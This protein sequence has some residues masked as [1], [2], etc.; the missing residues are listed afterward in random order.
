M[1]DKSTYFYDEF[2]D[3]T[4]FKHLNY[5]NSFHK[6]NYSF[7]K[8]L[9]YDFDNLIIIPVTIN[10]CLKIKDFDFD[11][12]KYSKHIIDTLNEGFS[13][14]SYSKYKSEKYNLK[15][16][17][18]LITDKTQASIIF[19]Y[20]NC[21]ND[22]KIRFFLNSID[23]HDK[24]F[25]YD[26]SSN[27]DFNLFINN[28]YSK[29][30]IIKNIS[31]LNINIIN[32]KCNSIGISTFP[33]TNFIYNSNNSNQP[34]NSDMMIFIDYKTIHPDISSSKYNNSKTVIHEVG[35]ILGLKHIFDTKESSL[36][37]YKILLGKNI[38][39]KIFVYNYKSP[40]QLYPDVPYQ[41]KP[42]IHNPI[43]SNKFYSFDNIPVNFCCF[44]DYSPDELLTHFTNSQILIMRNIINIYK[45][46]F[47]TGTEK[48]IGYVDSNNFINN[49]NTIINLPPGYFIKFN[50]NFKFTFDKSGLDDVFFQYKIHF[51]SKNNYTILKEPVVIKK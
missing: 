29:K 30:F 28:F 42:T 38:F 23:F 11:F 18:K 19:N 51:Y 37:S 44:M 33:W 40:N 22:S 2:D 47:I 3:S 7:N 9:N 5:F 15:Y 35:H 17:K 16:F 6:Q 48:Y 36:Q 32:F 13:G 27:P 12:I 10:I 45:P 25:S 31:D 43:E 8:Y 34:N 1:N 21:S 4:I 20:I 49:S 24:T 50:K 39:D 26:Y 14:N 46:E 41:K